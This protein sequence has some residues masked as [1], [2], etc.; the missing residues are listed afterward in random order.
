MHLEVIPFED[1]GVVLR[2]NPI[3]LQRLPF[4]VLNI[5]H[6]VSGMPYL[7]C[8]NEDIGLDCVLSP[9][10]ML[11]SSDLI[12]P[13]NLSLYLFIIRKIFREGPFVVA[14]LF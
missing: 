14:N 11:P 2:R 3:Y 13:I 5:E 10:K 7:S 9:K 8:R 6:S 12:N 1:S 4:K